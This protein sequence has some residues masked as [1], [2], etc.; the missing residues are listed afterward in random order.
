LKREKKK[1]KERRRSSLEGV[2]AETLGTVS[3]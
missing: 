3:K 2:G 1:K